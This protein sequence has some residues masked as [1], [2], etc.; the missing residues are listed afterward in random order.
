[1]RW[2]PKVRGTFIARW[3]GHIIFILFFKSASP[4]RTGTNEKNFSFATY[5]LRSAALEG[6]NVNF[7]WCFQEMSQSSCVYKSAIMT[8][9]L[10]FHEVVDF[11]YY[12]RAGAKN[13][14]KVCLL[15]SSLD[16][17]T[18]IK[19]LFRKSAITSLSKVLWTGSFCG[20]AMGWRRLGSTGTRI[21]SLA[22]H[23]G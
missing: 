20:A 7:G 13:I 21:W 14:R 1:M 3:H 23:S 22:R 2:T 8:L 4:Q 11:P 6:T 12:I 18:S 9:W 16:A 19:C 10:I 15:K 5:N 17:V